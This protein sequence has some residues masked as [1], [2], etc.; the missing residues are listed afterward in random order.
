MSQLLL[1][2]DFGKRDLHC[3]VLAILMASIL[4]SQAAWLHQVSDA[5]GP[6]S[7]TQS[8]V[9]HAGA[10]RNA[11]GSL[12]KG[13]NDEISS[14]RATMTHVQGHEL[15]DQRSIQDPQSS[16]FTCS[17]WGILSSCQLN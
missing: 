13:S 1:L 9:C 6:S 5:D 3:L 16:T 4:S 11:E 8:A 10:A 14:A 17:H 12:T 15:E 7:D 2:E